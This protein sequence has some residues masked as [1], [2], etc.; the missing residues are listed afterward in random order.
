MRLKLL[1]SALDLVCGLHE[2]YDFAE[3]PREEIK[4]LDPGVDPDGLGH[5]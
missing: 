1:V 4:Q 2:T 5:L 3:K